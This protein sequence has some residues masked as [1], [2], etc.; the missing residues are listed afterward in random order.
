MLIDLPKSRVMD[1]GLR[2]FM[3][4]SVFWAFFGLIL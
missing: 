2:I 4:I 3:E 1:L